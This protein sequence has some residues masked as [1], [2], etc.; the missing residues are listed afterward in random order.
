[1]RGR[2]AVVGI[3]GF[4]EPRG[5]PENGPG[6]IGGVQGRAQRCGAEA[7]AAR[8]IREDR[9][10]VGKQVAHLG[11]QQHA[12]VNLRVV[13]QT[14]VSGV[15]PVAAN[16]AV[17]F[18]GQQRRRGVIAAIELAVDV[19]ALLPGGLISGRDYVH[20]IAGGHRL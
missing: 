1:M 10:L 3:G 8:E 19:N 5:V 11:R 2:Y 17:G 6:Q 13:R 12:A 4:T 16:V 18:P 7:V 15:A 14:G 9:T 20:I